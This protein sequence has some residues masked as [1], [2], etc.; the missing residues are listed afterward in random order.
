MIGVPGAFPIGALLGTIVPSPIGEGFE[1]KNGEFMVQQQRKKIRK[2]SSPGKHQT[3]WLWGADSVID[4]LEA[5]RWRVYELFVTAELMERF[6]DLLQAKQKEGAELH[7]V[8]AARL[9]ELTRNPDHQGI[10][11]RVSKYPY[12]SMESL[13][14]SVKTP[15]N[16]ASTS[17]LQPLIVVV[18]RV[19]DTFSFAAILR[20]CE[21]AGVR[22]VIVGEHCQAQVT[23][24]VARASLGAVNH[25]PIV[26]TSDLLAALLLLKSEGLA[27]LAFD[28]TSAEPVS[29]AALSRS[30]VLLIGSDALGLDA[31]L[32]E[33]CDQRVSI[34]MYG[35]GTS[36]NSAVVS[37]VLLYEI[38]RQQSRAKT[39]L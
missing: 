27:L 3:N 23:T 29:E 18:D 39:S 15:Q 35:K 6:S 34:P 20:C 38:R 36:I 26:Q 10:V 14:E 8:S 28:S 5:A 4:T 21:C 7:V 30:T 16:D 17:Q 11:A 24:Q 2:N 13:L 37:G 1:N 31:R 25:F 12:E 32:L 22:G 9:E 33:A 19:Q